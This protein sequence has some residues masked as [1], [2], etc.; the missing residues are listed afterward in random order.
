M[1]G[2]GIRASAA[3]TDDD[4]TTA[5]R[6]DF[7]RDSVPASVFAD[8][9]K[10]T[11]DGSGLEDDALICR[12]CSSLLRSSVPSVIDDDDDDDG[13]SNLA[14]FLSRSDVTESMS[15]RCSE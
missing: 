15:S 6:E 13:S 2:I 8:A 4:L 14:A 10:E 5:A 3:A 1:V 7:D 9:G 12:G 11:A